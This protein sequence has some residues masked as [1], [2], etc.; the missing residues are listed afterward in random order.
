LKI[1]SVKLQDL[2]PYEN[3]PRL[4]DNAIDSVMNSIKEF[5]FKVPIIITKQNVIVAGHTRFIAAQKLELEEVPCI[6]ADDLSE[7]QIKAFRLA[8]NKVSELAKWDFSK[9]EME[10]AELDFDMSVFGFPKINFTESFDDDFEIEDDGLGKKQSP[11]A[12]VKIG[13]YHFDITQDEYFE[14]INDIQLVYGFTK[15]EVLTGLKAR[16]LSCD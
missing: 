4:N 11:N 5:G 13:E 10:L 15:E 3:N 8:D 14:L 1:L 2:K 16:L 12:V 9:L 7:Q 6:V